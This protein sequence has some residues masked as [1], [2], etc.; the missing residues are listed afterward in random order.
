MSSLNCPWTP[1]IYFNYFCFCK[2]SIN[3]NISL[4]FWLCYWLYSW[5]WISVLAF[6][7]FDYKLLYPGSNCTESY[8][9]IVLLSPGVKVLFRVA[10]VILKSTLGTPESL[11]RCAGLYESMQVLKNIPMEYLREEFLVE[12][13]RTSFIYLITS[14]LHLNSSNLHCLPLTSLTCNKDLAGLDHLV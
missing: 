7:A 5:C 11:R 8:G 6:K 4:T 2:E 9:K 10:L 1:E 12:E 13:V 3:T 14:Y